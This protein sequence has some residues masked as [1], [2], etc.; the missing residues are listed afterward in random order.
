MAVLNNGFETSRRLYISVIVIVIV[1]FVFQSVGF[2]NPGWE[3]R[4]SDPDNGRWYCA[5]LWYFL[6][7]NNI[8]GCVTLPIVDYDNGMTNMILKYV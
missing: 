3:I 5:S 7:C 2:V 4:S 6:E 8:T 1:A